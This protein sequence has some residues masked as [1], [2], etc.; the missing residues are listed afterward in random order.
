MNHDHAPE[1]EAKSSALEM[2]SGSWCSDKII[3]LYLEQ[4]YMGS[5]SDAELVS[6]LT[7][8]CQKLHCVRLAVKTLV[9]ALNEYAGDGGPKSTED[10]HAT[11]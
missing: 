2:L 10:N 3:D 9:K 11:V 8:P 1:L 5:L 7:G 4:P 6:E